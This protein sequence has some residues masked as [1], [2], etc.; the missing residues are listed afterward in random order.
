MSGMVDPGGIGIP[1]MPPGMFDMSWPGG[2]A[3][4]RHRSH[5]VTG[6]THGLAGLDFAWA[7][8]SIIGGAVN[9]RRRQ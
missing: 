4:G 6:V 1:G 2:I 3:L 5:V 8:T 7:V 9:V